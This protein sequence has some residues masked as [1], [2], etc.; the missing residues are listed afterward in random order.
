MDIVF[1]VEY[2]FYDGHARKPDRTFIVNSNAPLH[3]TNKIQPSGGI[4]T[5]AENEFYAD[6]LFLWRT[7]AQ[8]LFIEERSLMLTT[9]GA[10]ICIDFSRPSILP[11]TSITIFQGERVFN[12]GSDAIE[13]P[14]F[15]YIRL[16]PSRN[17]DV[18]PRSILTS[19]SHEEL[20]LYHTSYPLTIGTP[21]RASITQR[22][23]KNGIAYCSAEGQLVYIRLNPQYGHNDDKHDEHVLRD[24]GLLKRFLGGN[25]SSDAVSDVCLVK[26]ARVNE[27][28][29]EPRKSALAH[30][31]SDI[32]YA[33]TTDGWLRGWNVDAQRVST[34]SLDLKPFA[35][36]SSVDNE[37]SYL[38]KS[39]QI[40]EKDVLLVV[41]AVSSAQ[42]A[43]FHFVKASEDKLTYI[44]S[45]TKKQLDADSE[46]KLMDFALLKVTPPESRFHQ[47]ESSPLELDEQSD[48]SDE[49]EM[50]E[51]DEDGVEEEYEIVERSLGTKPRRRRARQ[52]VPWNSW[53][54]SLTAMWH[55]S[56][57]SA[58]KE[59][60][61]RR[62]VV[63]VDFDDCKQ[64]EQF[65]W[66]DVGRF[67][68]SSLRSSCVSS[69]AGVGPFSD[70]ES[71]SSVSSASPT[72][73]PP[74]AK[75]DELRDVVFNVDNYPFD[76]VHRAVRI[77]CEGSRGNSIRH[78]S[79]LDLAKHVEMYLD[80]S[81][82]NSHYQMKN[83]RGLRLR[84]G[85]EDIIAAAQSK[86]WRALVNACDELQQSARGPISLAAVQ[87]SNDLRLMAVVHKDRFTLLRDVEPSL[88][89]AV[90]G[91]GNGP[92]VDDRLLPKMN[93][94]RAIA[95]S[96]LRLMNREDHHTALDLRGEDDIRPGL[97]SNFDDF[98]E[99]GNR[100]TVPATLDQTIIGLVEA[101]LVLVQ[102]DRQNF[103]SELTRSMFGGALTQSII[104]ANISVVISQRLI[105]TLTLRTLLKAIFVRTPSHEKEHLR[106]QLKNVIKEYREVAEQLDVKIIKSG[107]KMSLCTWMVSDA[108]GLIMVRNEGAFKPKT[109]IPPN[110]EVDFN[111]F[112]AV[113]VQ[114]AV[115]ALLPFSETF[116]LAKRLISNR[117]YRILKMI[118]NDY[119][120]ESDPLRPAINFYRGIAFSG[121]DHPT[122]AMEA[123]QEAAQGFSA[124]NMAVRRAVAG[125]L[126]RAFKLD[127]SHPSQN[128]LDQLTLAEYYL[129]VLKFL[130]D[131]GY[132]E[133]VVNV[134]IHAIETL[135]AENES[136][137]RMSN[138]L[139][140][141]LTGRQEWSK[142]LRLIVK[143]SIKGSQ[144]RSSINELLGL[145][146]RAD[147]WEEVA[148]MIY[149]PYE[150]IVE[151]FLRD[152]ASRQN[153]SEKRHLYE[154]LFS[155]HVARQDYRKGAC[156]LYEFARY[157]EDAP[158]MTLALLKKRRDVLSSVLDVQAVLSIE[159]EPGEVVLDDHTDTS[160]VFPLCTEEEKSFKPK[161]LPTAP[162]QAPKPV[163]PPPR[164]QAPQLNSSYSTPT[165]VD[166]SNSSSSKDWLS[167]PKKPQISCSSSANSDSD[168]FVQCNHQPNSEKVVPPPGRNEEMDVESSPSGSS[169]EKEHDNES[170]EAGGKHT[171]V[172]GRR[173]RVIVI[174]ENIVR[175]EYI[176]SSALVALLTAPTWQGNLPMIPEDL[177][178]ACV[179]HQL[180]DFAF[181]VA[182]HFD[183]SIYELMFAVTREAIKLDSFG[184]RET[185]EL[186]SN[187]SDGWVRNNRRHCDMFGGSV[188][189]WAIVRGILAA[190]RA[191][192]PADSRPLRGSTN[193][194]LSHQLEAPCWLHFEYLKHDANDYL[195]CLVDYDH[196]FTALQVIL[197]VIDEEI[198]KARSAESKTWLPYGVIDEVL[199][200]TAGSAQKPFRTKHEE[201]NAADIAKLRQFANE[202]LNSY[203]SRVKNHEKAYQMS[204][205]FF[206][207]R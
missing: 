115:R 114:G 142:A 71:E 9:Q 120:T 179:D 152:A 122:K 111:Y 97:P 65:G 204:C 61:L 49:V 128:L 175:G 69:F 198:A 18:Q 7:A 127:P 207:D 42:G 32:A 137:R 106:G 172:L 167:P 84:A 83:E 16:E 150:D 31:D 185:V 187:I 57:Q 166:T 182:R 8:K 149:G 94:A 3:S 22:P 68:A 6:R 173:Q 192:W 80:S 129:T 13:Y 176:L 164:A 123:F 180:Y 53:V 134:A 199:R 77:V 28:E 90:C 125:L 30:A 143:T 43:A 178:K 168:G 158:E 160:L 170:S 78:G 165:P 121:T 2:E 34:N 151:D 190:A 81:E 136:V 130:Q 119:V 98:D 1:G 86:F 35:C 63:A 27:N 108:E 79:W 189:H 11:G 103:S 200:L 197:E 5:V 196:L 112:L 118:M 102:Y 132:G 162:A 141:H 155:F 184:D 87:L 76:V 139:F 50:D 72:N 138:T 169:G 45:Q 64:T 148:T 47:R 88:Y 52:A 135:P 33:V 153:P 93:E 14:S 36:F 131:N 17:Y 133:E 159:P 171:S 46:E 70:T 99:D 186:A 191:K 124:G 154:L 12:C 104:S 23:S 74:D 113:T 161:Q 4:V 156:A 21:L 82:F 96:R 202:K 75:V 26:K 37:S 188:D 203:F 95:E 19:I 91:P 56:S 110:A 48:D 89:D 66:H 59:Y 183:L 145:M 44:G 55:T 41:A 62:V 20:F 10:S 126:P 54:L 194:F 205:N 39:Y 174:T 92:S 60:V 107:A 193:A 29:I 201:Q 67:D 140:N 85:A 206:N 117:Q 157:I 101:F 177:Y 24:G 100:M 144:R 38:I 195:R 163:A 147:A 25:T 73:I 40:D 105:F 116:V 181:D 109:G 51:E 146:L 15:F 58:R